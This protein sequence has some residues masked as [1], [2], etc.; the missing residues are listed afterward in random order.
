MRNHGGD[1]RDARPENKTDCD[2]AWAGFRQFGPIESN[3][4]V[5]VLD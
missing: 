1:E 5:I 4:F 2:L 3:R